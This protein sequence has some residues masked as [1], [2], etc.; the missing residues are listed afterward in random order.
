MKPLPP[1]AL[2][3]LLLIPTAAFALR[4]E[5]FGNRPMPPNP[6]WAQGLAEVINL[7]SRVYWVE[8]D[9]PHD[10]YFRGKARD[11][12]EALARFARVKDDARRLILMPGPARTHSFDK[13]PIDFDWR[14]DLARGRYRERFQPDGPN[15]RVYISLAKPRPIDG[16]AVEKWI[17][18]LDS[19]TFA[20]RDK[21]TQELAK[22][23]SDAK[24]FL[25]AALKQQIKLEKRRRIENLLDRLPPGYD[26]TDFNIPAALALVTPDDLL[27]QNLKK[28]Q[29]PQQTFQCGL[30][31]E[32]LAPMVFYS[33]KVIPAITSLLGK[34][35]N[36]WLRRVAALNLAEIGYPARSA[37]PIL[38]EGLSDPDQNVRKAFATAI[39]K[40]D[41]A[42]ELPAEELQRKRAIVEDIRWAK[43][44]RRLES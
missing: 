21:A 30:A 7:P 12:H 29:S 39:E 10:Y 1:L 43:E 11:L 41:K 28:L 37:L 8:G 3:A 17:A 2:F 36:E 24:P 23:G 9:G 27:A 19:E 5:G 22:L 34:N 35:N 13:R 14:L 31:V 15:L 4:F 18:D 40:L 26:V 6:G 16:A 42:V 33:D 20:P 25:R 44:G 32:E 38:K